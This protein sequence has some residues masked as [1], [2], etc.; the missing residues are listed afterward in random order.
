MQKIIKAKKNFYIGVLLILISGC[1]TNTSQNGIKDKTGVSDIA[2]DN[3]FGVVIMAH[4][5]RDKWNKGVLDVVEPLKVNYDV[6]VAFGMADAVSIQKS[7]DKLESR[8][9][10]QIAVIRMYVSGESWY[11]RTEQILGISQGAPVRPAVKDR[12]SPAHHGHS[13]EFWKLESDSRFVMSQQGLSEATEMNEVLYFRAKQLSKD[14]R[15]EDLL[16]LAHG[17]GD[18]EENERW[19]KN[20]TLRASDIKNK[21]SFN[22]VK[23]ETLREDWSGKRPAAEKR[24][25]RFVQ[26]AINNNRTAI[27]IPYR[28]QGFGPY[29]KVLKDLDYKSNE[30]GLVPHENVTQWLENQI[31]N[32]RNHF[33]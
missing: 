4:G 18:D 24:I 17:P 25:R 8:G 22:L 9:V 27:V 29:A 21:M 19:I 2:T 23:I 33:N 26:D 20:I 13:M 6:E 31:K 16:I 30:T 10:N 12:K 11:E 15:N 7:V 1:V 32:L 3:R 14:A 28:V 5:G